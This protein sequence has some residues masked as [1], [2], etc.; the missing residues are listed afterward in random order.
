MLTIANGEEKTFEF[1]LLDIPT[2]A[3]GVPTVVISQNT[4]TFPLDIVSVSAYSLTAK[5]TSEISEILAPELDTVLQMSWNNDGDILV[6][7]YQ[8]I[9]VVE[10]YV[11]LELEDLDYD[12]PEHEPPDVIEEEDYSEE[13]YVIEEYT[14]TTEQEPVEDEV[15]NDDPYADYTEDEGEIEDFDEDI[16]DEEVGQ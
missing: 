13:G 15:N 11:P 8:E 1:D 7:P 9:D 16:D 10:Q 3:L 6:F 5:I 12:D 4:A 2:S 14:D